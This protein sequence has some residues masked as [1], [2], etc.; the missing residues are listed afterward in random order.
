MPRNI[1]VTMKARIPGKCCMAKGTQRNQVAD[2]GLANLK[3][4]LICYIS[5]TRWHLGITYLS[6]VLAKNSFK[7]GCPLRLRLVGRQILA[8]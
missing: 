3:C 1:C 7:E 2:W 5:L 6:S 4:N 8:K